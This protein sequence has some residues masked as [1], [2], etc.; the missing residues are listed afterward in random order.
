MNERKNIPQLRFKGFDDE[1][2]EKNFGE[3]GTVK[4]GYSFSS[5]KF[6]KKGIPVIR[7]TNIQD[8]YISFDDLVC[9]DYIKLEEDFIAH[10]NDI[11]LAMSGATT[12]KIGVYNKDS[13]SYINQRVGKFIFYNVNADKSFY[14]F[15]FSSDRFINQLNDSLA[16]GAQPNIGTKNIE[17]MFFFFPKTESEQQK[18]GSF[19]SKLDENIYLHQK[20]VDKLKKLKNAYLNEMFPQ[21][22]ETIPKRRFAGFIG[23]WEETK[24]GEI[25]S[26]VTRKNENLEST[27]PLTISAQ[28]GLINQTDF[29][30]KQIASKDVS[31]YFLVKKGEFAY[32]KSTSVDAPWGAIKRLDRYDL[33]V[34]STLYIVFSIK[35]ETKSCS[36]FLVTYYETDRWYNEIQLIAAEGARNHGLLNITPGDFFE[37]KLRIPSSFKEQQKIGSFF[38]KLDAQ[39]SSYQKELDKLKSLK[40]AYLKEMFV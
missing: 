27:L 8:G 34:L 33:G 15:L 9:H 2:E 6:N 20:K 11:L 17:N 10:K 32:N 30:N 12:G 39:I 18:I 35:D 19:F 37:T 31:G 40:S 25:V 16:T 1:W 3:K 23:D 4:S 36:D 5:E 26:R 28:Y 29:F 13:I 22:D 7:I 14:K 38:R 24:L 21:N